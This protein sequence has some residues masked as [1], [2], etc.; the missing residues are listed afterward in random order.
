MNREDAAHTPWM[1]LLF[2]TMALAHPAQVLALRSARPEGPALAASG[3]IRGLVP[4]VRAESGVKG[5]VEAE[6]RLEA[7]RPRW[8]ERRA[9]HWEVEHRTWVQ[10]GGYTGHT[11]PSAQFSLYFGPRR[12]FR[13][14]ECAHF[15]PDYPRFYY[16]GYWFSIVDPWPEYWDE[17]WCDVDD[18]YIVY[19][20]DGYYLYNRR[21]PGVALALAVSR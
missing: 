6:G 3:Q 17:D 10:R 14:S 5:R 2:G 4:K 18:V 11:I 8:H 7:S 15:D 20:F 19:D 12:S 13:I 1:F 16:Q 9:R 21:H